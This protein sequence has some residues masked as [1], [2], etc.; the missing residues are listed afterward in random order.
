MSKMPIA[1]TW[2]GD[3]VIEKLRFGNCLEFGI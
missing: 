2:A 3:W 1:Q